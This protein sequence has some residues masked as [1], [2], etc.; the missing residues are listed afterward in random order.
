VKLTS[1]AMRPRFNPVDG[2]L[3]NA[4]LKGWQSNAAKDGGFD[5]IR[6]TG[7]PVVSIAKLNVTKAGVALTFTQPL[8]K[9]TAEDAQNYAGE[10]WNY[11]RTSDYGSPEFKLTKSEDGK[12]QRGHDK[13]DIT[14]AKLSADGKTVTL[15]ITDLKVVNQQL[16]KFHLKTAAGAELKQEVLHT[17]NVIP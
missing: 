5:R 17:I 16:L 15:A 13:L 12:E 7:K 4:G 2:Q 6:Y 1:S 3:Y 9:A 14:A 8:D 11:K 10:R